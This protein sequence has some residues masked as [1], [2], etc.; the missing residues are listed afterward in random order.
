M[1][2]S[3]L[4]KNGIMHFIMQKFHNVCMLHGQGLNYVFHLQSED[5]VVT[6]GHLC[7]FELKLDRVNVKVRVKV[8]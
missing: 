8:K 6:R 3:V 4:A 7:C 5:I 2:K 1:P